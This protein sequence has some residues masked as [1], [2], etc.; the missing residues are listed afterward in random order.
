VWHAHPS[1]IALVACSLLLASSKSNSGG[2]GNLDAGPNPSGSVILQGGACILSGECIGGNYCTQ[3]E[4]CAASG[5]GAAGAGCSSEGDCVPGLLCAQ[6]G[7]TGGCQA[8][9]TGDINRGCVQTAD[10]MAGLLCV[11]GICTK[12]VLSPWAGVACS[13]VEDNLAKIYFHAPRATDPTVNT[14]FYRLPFPNDIRLKNGKVS[15]S[16]HP[17]PG[18]RILPFDLCRGRTSHRAKSRS[19]RHHALALWPLA[20]RQWRLAGGCPAV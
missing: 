17:K 3:Q 10:C 15:M 13:D 5:K 19:G 7:L 4:K 20:G 18:P 11:G 9:G 14:D 8:Q 12:A 6:T 2:G 1:P 16:G